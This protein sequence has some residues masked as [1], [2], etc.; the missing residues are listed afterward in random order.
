MLLV[1]LFH[2]KKRTVQ[3]GISLTEGSQETLPPTP[4]LVSASLKHWAALS[5]TQCVCWSGAD[6]VTHQFA[7]DPEDWVTSRFGA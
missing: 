7:V 6:T 1:L 3:H 5:L 4:D 2:G